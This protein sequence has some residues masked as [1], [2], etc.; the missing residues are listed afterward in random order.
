M[1]AVGGIFLLIGLGSFFA[2]FG[3]FGPPR[4]FWCAFIGLPL[5][6][7]GVGITRFAYMGAITRYMASEVAP[8]GKDTFNY[9]AD[10]THDG[11]RTVA[12]AVG[13][14]LGLRQA[15]EAVQAAACCQKCGADNDADAKFCKQCGD[16][17]PGAAA[18]P[19][20][21]ELNDPDANF[22]DECGAPLGV[23]EQS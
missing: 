9:M 1:I 20:C 18:C 3:S 7:L 11:I 23:P 17:I 4:Y 6:G 14:G 16:A 13:E 5:L 10:G 21:G 12:R 19:R 15:G 22:C 8:V 2:S